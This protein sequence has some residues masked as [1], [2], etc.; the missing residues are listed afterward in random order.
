MVEKENLIKKIKFLEFKHHGMLEKKKSLLY[1]VDGFK[2]RLRS[3]NRTPSFKNF[4]QNNWEREAF[5][6][7]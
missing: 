3:Q 4:D 1:E 5:R 6:D 2:K 7:N